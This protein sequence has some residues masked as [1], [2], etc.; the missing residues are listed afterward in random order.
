MIPNCKPDVVT[1]DAITH[2]L[3]PYQQACFFV[4]SVVFLSRGN[5][6]MVPDQNATVNTPHTIAHSLTPYL[7]EAN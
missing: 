4:C 5:K 7:Q 2:A 6:A 1:P 3:I